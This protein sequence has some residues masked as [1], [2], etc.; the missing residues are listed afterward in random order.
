MQGVAE[1]A[2]DVFGTAVRV[3]M[4]GEHIGGLCDSV[5]APRFATVA[6][7][8]LYGAIASRSAARGE[9][10]KRAAIAA[11]GV[12]KLAQRVKFWLQDFFYGLDG[13]D[14]SRRHAPRSDVGARAADV[15]K[16]GMW[17]RASGL[18]VMSA[19][20]D[21]SRATSDQRRQKSVVAPSGEKC[22]IAPMPSL[23]W[24]APPPTCVRCSL[25][26]RTPRQLPPVPTVH[27]TL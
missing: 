20:R 19:L 13:R 6:G 24:L 2:S 14:C 7:L 21:R 11:P 23:R 18:C 10:A 12:D 4:P 15:I 1:L 8:A 22:Y 5:E 9:R 27:S 3:G 16:L 17:R 25:T 26:R